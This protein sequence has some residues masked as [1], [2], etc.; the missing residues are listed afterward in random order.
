MKSETLFNRI[1][2]IDTLLTFEGV[3]PSLAG[4]QL[5][6]V[7]LIDTFSKALIA[8]E[9]EETQADELCKI[10]CGYL[11]QHISH[12]L[13]AYGTD[14]QR[15]LLDRHFYGH[16][17][18][19]TPLSERF[20]KLLAS[21]KGKIFDYAYRLLILIPHSLI[22]DIKIEKL[23]LRYA[24][25]P[26]VKQKLQAVNN[27][28]IIGPWA[29]KWFPNPQTAEKIR[30]KVAAEKDDLAK[31]LEQLRSSDNTAD[32]IAFF[33]VLPDGEENE[34]SILSQIAKWRFIA[35]KGEKLPCILGLYAR[36]SQDR[37]DD[38]A[39]QSWWTQAR[40]RELDKA[41]RRLKTGL[42]Q[43]CH[44]N[45]HALH[46]YAM[47]DI[48]LCWLWESGI[49]RSLESLFSTSS[50]TLDTVLLADY[51]E[52]FTRH[53][54][55]ANWMGNKF[56]LYPGLSRTITM[57]PLPA[58]TVR[59]SPETLAPLPTPLPLPA[60]L[61]TPLPLPLPAP[62]FIPVSKSRPPD[63]KTPLRWP[64]IAWLLTFALAGVGWVVSHQR[65]AIYKTEMPARQD[66]VRARQAH[67]IV[68]VFTQGSAALLPE[69]DKALSELLPV[70]MNRPGRFLIVGHSDNTGTHRLNQTISEKRAEAV[71]DWLVNHTDLPARRFITRGEGDSNPV[72]SNDTAEGRRQNRRV[73][74]I[75]LADNHLIETSK[76]L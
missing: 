15:Y 5:K 8:E 31:C 40:G 6:L 43:Q 66:E 51:S 19:A 1:V 60:P 42:E 48:L 23:R 25:T 50:F 33:P 70:V 32:V 10:L 73:E 2:C 30:W 7:Q 49:V 46:R 74:L 65:Q 57:P 62:L 64:A 69:N 67:G 26:G 58:F 4:F 24:V 75:P 28:I 76:G 61:P 56:H 45:V 29:K 47:A 12:S 44:Q 38:N 35:K 27:V 16:D 52:G 14:W 54:A 41:F 34:A 63:S 13:A 3:I 39:E 9:G 37:A 17:P 21:S 59:L 68:T 71:R 20:E 53:G 36:L 18:A 72:A 55:W 11:D 22:D